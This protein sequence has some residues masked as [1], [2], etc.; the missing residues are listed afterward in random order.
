MLKF[1]K[2]KKGK[3]M[4]HEILSRCSCGGDVKI[5]DSLFECDRCKAKVWRYSF[6]R[7]FKEKEAKKLFKG[8]TVMLKGFKSSSNNLYNTKA[9][10]IDGQVELIFDDDTCSTTLFLCSCG[11]EVTKINKGYKCNSCQKIVWDR[12]MNKL[13]TFRQVKRLFKGEG[14]KLENLKSQR[15]HIFN[16]EIFYTNNE[17]NLEYI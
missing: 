1:Y 15:G 4:K 7:E 16:A 10:I 9:H 2:F 3:I 6:H 8:E 17:L 11:G 14:L 12:F 5:Y 13:L